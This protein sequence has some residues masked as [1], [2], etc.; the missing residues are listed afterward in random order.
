L[1][2]A[3]AA[4]ANG[5][6]PAAGQLIVDPEDPDRLLLRA[7]YGF[8]Q[9]DDGGASWAWVCEQ[10]IGFAGVEDPAVAYLSGHAVIGG[11]STGL[12]RSTDGGCSWTLDSDVLDGEYVVDVSADK[13]DPSQAI[14]I[15]VTPV[16]TGLHTIVAATTDAGATWQQSGVELGADLRALTLDAAPSLPDRLYVTGLIEPEYSPAVLRTDDAGGVWTRFV[17]DEIAGVPYLSAVD[18]ANPDRIYVRFQGADMD[19]LYI[20]DDG[21]ETLE[22]VAT[23]PGEM[24]GFALSPDGSRVAI[25]GPSF[26]LQI[27]D[28]ADMAFEDVSTVGVRCLT[29]TASTLFVCADEA[30]DGFTL[31]TSA[32]EGATIEP[33]YHLTDLAPLACDGTKPVDEICPPNWP[34]VADLLGITTPGTTSST[35]AGGGGDG[36]ETGGNDGCCSMAG[37]TSRASGFGALLAIAL[38]VTSGAARSRA[39]RRAPRSSRRCS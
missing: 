26:G 9:S 22:M 24:L 4:S 29:W 35:G 28:T 34:G 7:T 5:R 39:G 16:K 30:A 14:A 20:S 3:S 2:F 8:V 37:S 1:S 21:G 32:D 19:A 18:P 12:S 10:A 36:D 31:G 17:H 6:Y 15:T 13:T 27:A 11:L 23:R 33:L 38:L 25:G